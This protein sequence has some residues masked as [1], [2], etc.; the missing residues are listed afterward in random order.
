M[1]RHDP[2]FVKIVSRRHLAGRWFVEPNYS[3]EL[4]SGFDGKQFLFQTHN[5]HTRTM[6]QAYIMPAPVAP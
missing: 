2:M 6:L 3:A 1:S 5:M 4:D